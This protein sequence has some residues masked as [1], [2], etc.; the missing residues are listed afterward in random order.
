MPIRFIGTGWALLLAV[1]TVEIFTQKFLGHAAKLAMYKSL[2]CPPPDDF[3]PI[4]RATSGPHA[5]WLE[6]AG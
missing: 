3:E 2:P 6:A 1:T 4:G 5:R